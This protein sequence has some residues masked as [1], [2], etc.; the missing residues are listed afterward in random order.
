VEEVTEAEGKGWQIEDIFNLETSESQKLVELDSV[1]SRLFI[2]L[3][4]MTLNEVDLNTKQLVRTTKINEIEDVTGSQAIAFALFKDLNIL[5]VSTGEH[6]HLLD[7]EGDLSLMTSIPAPNVTYVCFVDVFI[8]MKSETPD[9]S[10]C[11]LTCYSIDSTEAE[12]SITI[13]QFM[14]ATCQVQPSE[15]SVVFACGNQIGRVCVPEMEL[16]Y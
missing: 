10:E 1:G 16:Q 2:M 8:V 13:K 4:D 15:G 5:V 14:G 6:V 7:Y 9:G 12:A 11:I 3:S